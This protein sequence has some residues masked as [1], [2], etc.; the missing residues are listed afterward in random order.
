MKD[1]KINHKDQAVECINDKTNENNK[2]VTSYLLKNSY[3]IFMG[4]PIAL[5]VYVFDPQSNLGRFMDGFRTA[6]YYLKRANEVSPSCEPYER[7]KY[8]TAMWV[9]SLHQNINFKRALNPILG[10]TYEGYFIVEED[11]NES[12]GRINTLYET[13][14]YVIQRKKTMCKMSQPSNLK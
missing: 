9:S 4:K 6:P 13:N 10:E 11:F 8:L 3:K 12:F 7:M 14:N 1:L 5:P 2:S